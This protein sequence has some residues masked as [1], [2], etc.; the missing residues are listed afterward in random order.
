MPVEDGPSGQNVEAD[1]EVPF[2]EFGITEV[3]VVQ[4]HDN[5]AL[6]GEVEGKKSNVESISIA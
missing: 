1:M 4:H 5:E 3:I 6:E 2:V